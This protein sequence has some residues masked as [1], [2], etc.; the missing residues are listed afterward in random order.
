MARLFTRTAVVAEV[1]PLGQRFRRVVVEGSSLCEARWVP[2]QKVQVAMGGW[3]YRT[4]TPLSWDAE[5]GRVELLVFLHGD[6]PG[7]SWGREVRAGDACAFFG[8][9]DSIDLTSLE[10][11]GLLFGDE[12]SLGLAHALRFTPDGHRGVRVLLEVDAAAELA[13]PLDDLGLTDVDLVER[14]P[15]DTHLGQLEARGV[16]DIRAR[17][18]RGLVLSGK[19]SSIQRLH[20]P[21]RDAGAIPRSQARNRAYWAPGKRGLD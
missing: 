4:Y 2:G 1:R 16:D 12:T 7:A 3:T 8:P 20:R 6:A 14:Q 19:A 15:N 18:V 10:R 21:F 11:P 13:E 17:G 9:R 5:R